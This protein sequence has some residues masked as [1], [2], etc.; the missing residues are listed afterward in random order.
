M[1]GVHAVKS[2][3]KQFNKG[4]S[5]FLVIQQLPESVFGHATLEPEIFDHRTTN[6]TQIW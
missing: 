6:T 5:P 4:K 1:I 2:G 3:L